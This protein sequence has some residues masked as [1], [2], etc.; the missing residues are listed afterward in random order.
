[1][2]PPTLRP[3]ALLISSAFISAPR[4]SSTPYEAAPPESGPSTPIVSV[5]SSAALGVLVPAAATSATTAMVAMLARILI[6]TSSSLSQAAEKQPACLLGALRA[7]GSSCAFV[8]LPRGAEA[9]R[10]SRGR[11]S[12]SSPPPA[13]LDVLS[14]R[15]DNPRVAISAG[16]R[17]AY[18]E[19]VLVQA[20]V[21]GRW[22]RSAA[23]RHE[24]YLAWS[25]LTPTLLVILFL[26]AYPFFSAIY[27]SLQDKMVGAPGRFVGLANYLSLLRDEVFL[28]MA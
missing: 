27:L 23:A 26:V 17:S 2:S 19:D 24:S 15:T 16:P 13:R 4:T 6:V 14:T 9:R 10:V 11:G 22:R 25:L 28:R 20:P 5:L 12:Y 18:G 21:V 8:A 3:P 1:M 7:R